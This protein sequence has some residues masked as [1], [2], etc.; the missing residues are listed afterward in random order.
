M[1]IERGDSYN[2]LAYKVPKI[3]NK[4]AGAATTVGTVGAATMVVGVTTVG[5]PTT[6]V[7]AVE[8]TAVIPVE[9]IMVA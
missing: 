5:A 7:P 2:A 4:G 3:A 9:R 6:R 8:L 1:A